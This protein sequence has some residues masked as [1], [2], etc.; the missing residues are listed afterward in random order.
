MPSPVEFYT[1]VLIITQPRPMWGSFSSEH[2]LSRKPGMTDECELI[3]STSSHGFLNTRFFFSLPGPPITN[4]TAI[5]KL[6]K[7]GVV[8]GLGVRDPEDS[9][10]AY[11][12]VAWV[13]T[14]NS[15]QL[16]KVL[17]V[18]SRPPLTPMGTSPTTK[19]TP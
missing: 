6:L 18:V 17:K 11:Q 12:D 15:H 7:H 13:R 10:N 19:L 5:V 4:D 9:R 16:M 14:F 2:G 8:V 3:L 1:P